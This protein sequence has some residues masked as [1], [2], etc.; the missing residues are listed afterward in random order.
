MLRS[1]PA[2]AGKPP[3]TSRVAG[4]SQ[5]HPRERGEAQPARPDPAVRDGPSPRARGSPGRSV[6]HPGAGGSIPASA[7][8][9]QRSGARPAGARVHPRERGEAVSQM[10]RSVQTLGPSPRARGSPCHEGMAAVNAGSIPASAGKPCAPPGGGCGCRVHPRERGEAA[11]PR[12]TRIF[13]PGPSP[14]ARGSPEEAVVRRRGPGSI[15][16]SAGKPA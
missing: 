8:K 2:S 1:I 11:P 13:Y 15:P 14:R 10:C 9:P 16:A 4:Q 7:G 12:L 5:V 6:R 3:T